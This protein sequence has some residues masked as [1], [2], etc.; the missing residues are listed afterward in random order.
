MSMPPPPPSST[1][2]ETSRKRKRSGPASSSAAS[3]GSSRSKFPAATRDRV[4]SLNGDTCWHCGST[5]VDVCH[6]IA[7]KNSQFDEAKSAGLINFDSLDDVANGIP[8]CPLCHRNY[9][10]V[11]NPGFIFLPTDVAFFKTFESA[12]FRRRKDRY[13]LTQ[14]PVPRL[15]PTAEEYRLHCVS[16]GMVEQDS[17][18]G[19]YQAYV[20]NDYFHRGPC[21][22]GPPPDRLGTFFEAKTWNGDPM[23]AL[24]RAFVT[25]PKP[26]GFPL[27]LRQ[28][29][30]E[31]QQMYLLHDTTYM[32]DNTVLDG[33]V[34]HFPPG[35]TEH[36]ADSRTSNDDIADSAIDAGSEGQAGQ[37]GPRGPVP[38]G[39]GDPP[40]TKHSQQQ[41]QQQLELQI[42][43]PQSS[44]KCEANIDPETTIAAH[45]D[46]CQQSPNATPTKKRAL[47]ESSS[48]V[49]HLEHGA[50]FKRRKTKKRA[51]SSCN[52]PYGRFNGKDIWR[53]GPMQTA[54]DA[55]DFYQKV[56][57]L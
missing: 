33:S 36:D 3:S 4:K 13:A 15:S 25:L 27:A 12:D 39:N 7:Q 51:P 17:H 26:P 48:E 30:F 20:L 24:N 11:M 43:T 54:Q 10:A 2:S 21:R 31:L 49:V 32:G 40:Q 28:Q 18:G 23:A 57:K 42:L 1:T 35:D 38:G 34:F 56:A 55:V 6:V 44:Q 29:L 9:D 41:Q 53:W 19:L 47:S 16:K 22:A 5:P 14:M 46:A 8:L 45:P 37:K 52:S 50:W